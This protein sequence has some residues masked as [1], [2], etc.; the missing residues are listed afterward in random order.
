MWELDGGGKDR[1]R[2]EHDHAM[3]DMRY[4]V[5]T[6]LERREPG[7]VALAVERSGR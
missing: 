3:D 4:F 5:A 1:V 2:K 6:V 7:V